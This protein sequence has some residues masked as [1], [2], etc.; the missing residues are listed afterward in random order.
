M[1]CFEFIYGTSEKKKLIKFIKK[2]IRNLE[3]KYK[4][5]YLLRNEEVYK[6]YDFNEKKV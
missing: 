5:I 3:N 2:T 4:E 1:L 6:I